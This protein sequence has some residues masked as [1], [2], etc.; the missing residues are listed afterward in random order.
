MVDRVRGSDLA[1]RPCGV[2]GRPVRSGFDC[3]Y[4]CRTVGA[5]LGVRLVPVAAV[6]A[7]AVGDALHRLLRGYKDGPTPSLRALRIAEVARRVEAWWP[8]HVSELGER[9]GPW[10]AVTAVPS[11]RRERTPAEALVV[12]VPPLARRYRRLLQRGPGATGHLRAA[13]DGYAVAEGVGTDALS[14]R[15]VLVFDDSLTTGARA[16]SAAVALRAAGCVPVGILVVG[17][18]YREGARAPRAD[19]SECP[20]GA[21]PARTGM[22]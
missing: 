22:G 17:R 15:R 16:Q 3:C 11:S 20:P 10:D 12:A 14:G 18:A 1:G 4:C 9:F 19:R 21:A 7:Y 13:R 2:C 5:Q 6:S 8:Q